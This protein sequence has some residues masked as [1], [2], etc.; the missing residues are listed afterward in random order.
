MKRTISAMAALALAGL[1]GPAAMAADPQEAAAVAT[2][3]KL[4][5][6]KLAEAEKILLEEQP[7]IPVYHYVNADLRR[8]SV[9]GIKENPRN[10]VNFRDVYVEK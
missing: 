5:L 7:I 10:N 2:Q 3:P 9:K 8:A 1:A 4:R 6:A